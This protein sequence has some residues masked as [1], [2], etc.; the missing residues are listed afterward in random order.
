MLT[1]TDLNQTKYNII[2]NTNV[3]ITVK[4]NLCCCDGELQ[5]M[6]SS[7]EFYFF[8]ILLFIARLVEFDTF[9]LRVVGSSPMLADDISDPRSSGERI[10]LLMGGS[11]SWIPPSRRS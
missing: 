6:V 4:E 1:Q 2:T 3:Q 5:L 11:Q 8:I 10:E 7:R 9:N